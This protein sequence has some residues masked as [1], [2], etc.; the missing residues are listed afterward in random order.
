M[1]FTWVK[2]K[3]SEDPEHFFTVSYNRKIGISGV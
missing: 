2:N 3:K 1:L